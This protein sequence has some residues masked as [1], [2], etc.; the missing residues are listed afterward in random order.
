[1]T[2]IKINTRR[3][4]YLPMGLGPDLQARPRRRP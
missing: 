4:K 2:G 3:R 1:M